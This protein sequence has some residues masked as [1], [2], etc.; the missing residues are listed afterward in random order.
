MNRSFLSLG[1]L[2]GV[3]LAAPSY[4]QQTD[5]SNLLPPP[6]TF[7]AVSSTL[8]YDITLPDD[9]SVDNLQ[10]AFDIFSWATFIALNWPA[11]S[12]GT[13]MPVS[14]GSNLP[15]ERVWETWLTPDQVFKSSGSAPDV[16][17]GRNSFVAALVPN[18]KP[19]TRVLDYT[20]KVLNLGAAGVEKIISNLKASK[21]FAASPADALA[22]LTEIDQANFGKSLLPP[23]ADLNSKYVFYDSHL[24]PVEYKYI[25]D[26]GLYSASGQT[27]FLKTNAISFPSGNSDNKTYGAIEVKAAWKQLGNG[28]DPSK[29]Y[30]IQATVIDPITH[31]PNAEA[32]GLVGFH[33]I[34]R[35]ASAPDWIWATFEHVDNCPDVGATN[36]NS[37]YNFNDPKG[38]QS[39]SGYGNR[40]GNNNPVPN[41]SPTQITRVLNNTLINDPWTQCLNKTMQDKLHGQVWANYRLITTQWH[42][43]PD[44]NTDPTTFIPQNLTNTVL[45]TYIQ[46]SGSCMLCHKSAMTAGTGSDK[47]P[48]SANFSYFLQLAQ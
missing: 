44:P 46:K 2:L 47:S 4:A 9:I 1:C 17:G 18:A 34:A 43:P 10:R 31:Q 24:N 6:L 37:H 15:A 38:T 28:D 26:N 40:P 19:G 12:D 23:I 48:A 27:A 21:A 42:N 30:T 41:P 25:T 22:D 7:P 16:P 36:L 20:T 8:P 3:A 39:A 33:I 29:F 13:P 45:E 35:T 11:N 14:I 32:V 5:C